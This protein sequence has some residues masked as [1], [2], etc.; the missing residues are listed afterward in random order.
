MGEVV[1][2]DM[3][4]ILAANEALNKLMLDQSAPDKPR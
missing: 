1:D 4:F 3:G 2:L